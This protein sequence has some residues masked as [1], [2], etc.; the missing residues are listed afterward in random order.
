MSRPTRP[1]FHLR[2][3][4]RLVDDTRGGIL[5]F[6]VVLLV[7]VLGT[8][9]LIL[10]FSRVWNSQSELQAFAD[11]AALVAAGELDGNPDAITRSNAALAQLISDRQAYASQD[12]TLDSSDL[13][14]TFLSGLP[15]ADTDTNFGPFVTA[16]PALAQFVRVAVNPHTVSTIFANALLVVSGND[17]VDFDIGAAAVAGYTQFVCDITPLMICNPEEPFGNSD[18]LLPYTPIIGQ[19]IRLKMQSQGS[20]YVPGDFG[21]LD[22]AIDPNGPCP[23][24]QGA[25]SL[26]CAFA[27]V[28]GVTQCVQ[29]RGVDVRPG[30]LAEAF[31]T[32]VNVRFDM[33]QGSFNG[34]K[35]DPNFEA[36]PNVTKGL[37]GRGG[38]TCSNQFDPAPLPPDPNATKALPR[39]GCFG[40]NSCADGRFGDSR[41]GA[42]TWDLND[43]WV[44]N[45]GV[46]PPEQ[47]DTRFDAYAYE[48]NN[49]IPNKSPGG[50]NGNPTC[51]P[52]TGVA[53]SPERRVVVGAVINCYANNVKGNADEV[54]VLTFVKLFLTE[55]AGQPDTNDLWVEV[56]GELQPGGANSF[57]HD[58]VQLYR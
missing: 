5:A 6:S 32:G 58:F 14:V 24:N 16:D 21:L 47:F 15:A 29:K 23:V 20:S 25:A 7:F 56:V 52:P 3:L 44:T 19:Q 54:P 10:D 53:N 46:A 12:L 31:A 55:P 17:Q 34:S 43:Y 18:P 13:Q 33:F 48:Y 38:G 26:R 27:A 42:I 9:G 39:D 8:G 50:E 51:N 37:V 30:E 4:L 2:A 36:A 40:T 57:V 28:Q 45:H 11:H 35:S 49:S 22:A 41:K 1:N